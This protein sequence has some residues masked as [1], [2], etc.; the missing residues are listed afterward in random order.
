MGYVNP[1]LPPLEVIYERLN[2]VERRLSTLERQVSAMK[3]NVDWLT[4]VKL[5]EDEDKFDKAMGEDSESEF[6]DDRGKAPLEEMHKKIWLVDSNVVKGL[7]VSSCKNCLQHFKKPWAPEHEPVKD[8]LDAVKAIKP[9]VLIG[10]S[11]VERTFTKEEIEA[12][13]SFNENPLIMALSN[14]TLQFECTDEEAY[15][16]SQGHAI[17]ASGSPVDPMEYNSKVFV[18]GQVQG[19]AIFASGSPFDPMEYN[20]KANNAYIFPGFS[21]GL[22]ISGAIRVHDEMLLAA[23]EALVGQVTKENFDKVGRTFTKEVIEVMASF[24]EKPLV[25]ALSNP[26][27]Q[28]ECTVE[29]AYTWSQGHAIF[30]SGSP[31]DPVEYNGKLYLPGQAN[32]AYIFPRFGLGLVIS[33]AIRVHDEMLLAA[34]LKRYYQLSENSIYCFARCLYAMLL[35]WSLA[36]KGGELT[37]DETTIIAGALGLT[38]K[39]A[40]DAMTP[41]S[42]T[43][44]VDI[45]AKLDRELM[46]LILEKGHRR[47][48]VYYEQPTNII[49]LVLS[50]LENLSFLYSNAQDYA[51]AKRRVAELY[52]KHEKELIEANKI[53]MK[54]IEDDQFVDLM[55]LKTGVRFACKEPYRYVLK[56]E[57][58]KNGSSCYCTECVGF[59]NGNFDHLCW[60]YEI[61][62]GQ[63]PLQGRQKLPF[64]I[65]ILHMTLE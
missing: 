12:M 31:F 8:L 56:S 65:L 54:K 50:E 43:F 38:E 55:T 4:D 27:S 18:P 29:E 17:F 37:H 32:N 58:P 36:G 19:H 61:F 47:V 33:S 26:T 51:K 46:N 64:S 44:A 1:V 40:S 21:L 41:I 10:S 15:T 23:S 39:T 2:E 34:W 14:P 42:D 5:V 9:T 30:A 3:K 7:I 20:G 45:N 22:V 63:S 16:W 11:G 6:R 28:S 60:I 52:K 13:A 49:G 62:V 25:M 24:N 35:P 53:L 59:A 48:P 57:N